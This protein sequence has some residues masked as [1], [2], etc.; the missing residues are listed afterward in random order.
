MQQNTFGTVLD[1]GG[2]VS[3]KMLAIKL[4][5]RIDNYNQVTL[6]WNLVLHF[7]LNQVQKYFWCI[8]YVSSVFCSL[9]SLTRHIKMLVINWVLNG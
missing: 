5:C 8:K 3:Q 4:L 9:F 1:G 7:I 2:G 6:F